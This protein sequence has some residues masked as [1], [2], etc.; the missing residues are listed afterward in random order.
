MAR[1]VEDSDD[2]FP[3]IAELLISSKYQKPQLPS[4]DL[5]LSESTG[6]T[7]CLPDQVQQSS[8]PAKGLKKD[9]R[10]R[11]M[12]DKGNVS[13]GGKKAKKRVLRQ[14]SDN[15]LLQ[16]ISKELTR[17]PSSDIFE[18]TLASR[19]RI[20]GLKASRSISEKGQ[21]ILG[22]NEGSNEGAMEL[23]RSDGD[24]DGLSDFVVD[25]DQS[26]EDSVLQMPPP[27]STRKLIRGRR[28]QSDDEDEE[29]LGLKMDKRTI[30]KQGI[31]ENSEGSQSD[32]SYSRK[33]NEKEIQ[34]RKI[35]SRDS[36]RRKE[37]D[38]GT[39]NIGSSSEWEDPF[40]L[41]LLVDIPSPSQTC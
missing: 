40:I 10:G 17:K 39:T 4:S 36:G 6:L 16:P 21:Q 3:D 19:S 13:I 12:S 41:K 24:C 18:V 20:A 35:A 25:D 38:S 29:L 14:T 11:E 33:P 28:S 27:R 8:I 2:D 34:R 7:V 5:K 31:M 26:E 9:S 37:N 1:T 30:K 32:E 15:P 22:T 23:K